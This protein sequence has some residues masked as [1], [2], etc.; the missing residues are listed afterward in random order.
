M[1]ED[2]SAGD[3]MRAD[4]IEAPTR[5]VGKVIA[6]GGGRGGVGKSLVAENLAIYLAQLG[7]SVVLV[8]ADPTG[9]N[10]HA[11][12]GL[13][14]AKNDPALD[15]E[16]RI[17]LFERALVDTQVPGLRLLPAALDSIELPAILRPGRKGRWMGKLRSLT[18]DYL[19]VDVGPGITPFAIDTMLGADVPVCVAVPEPPAIEA[20]Y[21]FL[22]AA[23]RRR[24]RR[25]LLRD[26]FRLPVVDRAIAEVG[27]LPAPIDVVRVLQRMDK[28][29]A[30]LAWAEAGRMRMHLV[31][32]QTRVRTDLELGVWMSELSARHYGL[33]I[34][35]LGHIEHDDT[36]WLA[37]RR[38]RP[39]LVDSP[40]SKA[41]RNLE[42]IARRVIALLAVHS[43][44]GTGP[45]PL[46]SEPT[47]YATLGV[48]RSSSDEEIRRAYKRKKEIYADGGIAVSSLLTEPQLR[49]E[50]GRLDEAYDT[51]LDAV[52]RRAYD[53]STFPD[54]DVV[55]PAAAKAPRAAQ[56][57][58]LLL[59]S[60]LAREIG[61]DT[62]FTGE[63]LRRVR[64]SQGVE[65]AEISARTKIARTHLLAIEEERYADLPAPVYVRGFVSELAKFLRLDT[66]QVQRTYMRRVQRSLP[67]PASTTP[68]SPPVSEPPRRKG[69]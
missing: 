40:T 69:S 15:G 33:T 6:V 39:L 54:A 30:E 58:Q 23:Y 31:I 9:A 53:L 60:E 17:E 48:G 65:L 25:T 18:A 4:R 13:S 63:L 59:Q 20:T 34:E 29:V 32:N 26:R 16:E 52:R 56:A 68:K 55:A 19:V 61:P 47:L 41:A 27:M 67:P 2:E 10:L 66:A 35:E 11:H 57:E 49:S 46:P 42:R 62:E 1:R 51:L 8:D 28:S 24:L 36:V 14:A 5:G 38:L 45:R 22:R 64:E 43:D 50:Q 3:D 12:F 44:R 37:V 21:R 7:K